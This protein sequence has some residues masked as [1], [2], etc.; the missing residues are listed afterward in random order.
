[1][2]HSPEPD[3][4]GW[5]LAPILGAA[6]F[7]LLS[8]VV[9]LYSYWSHVFPPLHGLL[10]KT[11]DAA[12][13]YEA[14]YGIVSFLIGLSWLIFGKLQSSDEKESRMSVAIDAVREAHRELADQ[15]ITILKFDK[16]PNVFAHFHGEFR[17]FNAPMSWENAHKNEALKLHRERYADSTFIKAR[18]YY[19]IFE[20]LS[21]AERKD[22][23]DRLLRFFGDLDTTLSLSSKKKLRFYWPKSLP[24]DRNERV[25]ED[26]HDGWELSMTFF[27]GFRACQEQVIYFQP[28]ALFQSSNRV[29]IRAFRVSEDGFCRDILEFCNSQALRARLVR[30]PFDQFLAHLRAL[31]VM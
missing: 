26:W 9:P 19:P 12:H 6:F 24:L 18:Y 13:G 10:A 30:L 15:Q 25:V 27:H 11:F 22:W 5:K 16:E 2:S 7:F 8:I 3:Q 21:V 29:P 1:M 14:L 28:N 4:T 17:A 31:A 20:C 23:A